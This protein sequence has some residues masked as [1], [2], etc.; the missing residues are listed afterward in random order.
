[1]A[2]S[3]GDAALDRLLQRVQESVP[4]VHACSDLEDDADCA[5]SAQITDEQVAAFEE[6][7]DALLQVNLRSKRF[8]GVR[9]RIHKLYAAVT[10]GKLEH[11]RRNLLECRR[12]QLKK[13]DVEYSAKRRIR[14]QRFQALS[15]LE[16]ASRRLICAASDGTSNNVSVETDDA[17]T[18]AD[19]EERPLFHH[20]GWS[21]CSSV[22]SLLIV[23]RLLHLQATVR[24]PAS[25]LR[26]AVSFLRG[27]E[28]VQADGTDRSVGQSLPGHRCT[29]QDRV[30]MLQA[31]FGVWRHCLGNYPVPD[32]LCQAFLLSA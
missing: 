2:A 10:A 8:R 15:Q 27:P 5:A 17:G 22:D 29:Y 18:I 4:E 28:L 16:N 11:E 26:P 13:L 25:L 1:M 32:G 9:S 20:R 6:T 12:R 19:E 23:H 30:R 31:P 24:G 21:R 3:P 14:A 7:L